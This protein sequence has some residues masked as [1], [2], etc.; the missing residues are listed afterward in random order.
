MQDAKVSRKLFHANMSINEF[1]PELDAA[2]TVPSTIEVICLYARH[3]AA[4]HICMYLCDAAATVPSSIEVIC[5]Y[6][7]QHAAF[8]ICMYLCDAAA[9]VPSSIEFAF[10]HDNTRLFTFVCMCVCQYITCMYV[11]I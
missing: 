6:A 1:C 7:R 5:L 8:H 11:C 4:F 9:T 2:A 10:M 3:H